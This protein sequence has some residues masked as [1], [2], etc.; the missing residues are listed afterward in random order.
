MN[1]VR[2]MQIAETSHWRTNL[3]NM[4]Q[5]MALEQLAMHNQEIALPLELPNLWHLTLTGWRLTSN[6]DKVSMRRLTR[7]S[8]DL[9]DV[10]LWRDMTDSRTLPFEQLKQLEIRRR[11]TRYGPLAH[12][13][14]ATSIFQVLYLSTNISSILASPSFFSVVLKRTWRGSR[15]REGLDVEDGVQF[16]SWNWRGKVELISSFGYTLGELSGNESSTELETLAR[17]WG[18]SSPDVSWETLLQILNFS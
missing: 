10:T 15:L 17:D 4:E 3:V 12:S 11:P 18:L 8:L 1:N 16:T 14:L 7:L 2:R 9:G 13:E 6:I 5:A